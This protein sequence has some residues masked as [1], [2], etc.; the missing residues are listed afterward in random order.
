MAV[1]GGGVSGPV[2]SRVSGDEATVVV[3]P[4]Q[5]PTAG[6]P[7]SSGS[8]GR[9]R[10]VVALVVLLAAAGA[11]AYL[12][13]RGD[14]PARQAGP[15]DVAPSAADDAAAAR[16]DGRVGSGA[17]AVPVSSDADG[18]FTVTVFGTD[19]VLPGPPRGVR[20]ALA[21]G[22]VP[23]W[24]YDFEAAR[25]VAGSQPAPP[26]D[27]S[28]RQAV[29]DYE[30]AWVSPGTASADVEAIEDAI[31][32]TAAASGAHVGVVC[33]GGPS[34]EQTLACAHKIAQ[35]G[36]DAVILSD[37]PAATAAMEV[38]DEAGLPVVTFDVWHP[39]AVLVGDSSYE[40]GAVAG[41]HAGRHALD[42]WGCAGVHV[43][44]GNVMNVAGRDNLDLA[45]T[46]FA[47]G[48]RAVCGADVAVS[49]I[50]TTSDIAQ[51]TADWLTANPEVEH[52]VATSVT[53][54]LTV[55]MSR[56]IEQAGRSGIAAA[57]TTSSVGAARLAEGTTAET[58]YL[59]SAANLPEIHGTTAVA[60]L[61]D[62]LE[63]RPVPQE[64]HLDHTW[65]THNNADHPT[66]AQDPPNQTPNTPTDPTPPPTSTFTAITAGWLYS[67]AL[68]TDGAV[69]C[70]GYNGYSQADPPA[71]AF[72]AVTA[73]SDHSCGLRADNTVTCW[74]SN[75]GG[76]ADAPA[77]A[78]TAVSAGW[79]HSCGLRTD[80][81]VTCWGDNDDGRAD[82]PAG[83]FTAVSAGWW[84]S[85][86]L[87]TDNTIVCW[88]TNLHGEADAPAGA[89]TAVSAGGAYSCG[90]GADNTIVCW[91]GNL[92]GEADAPAGAFTAVSA[93]GSHSCG[94]RAD[95]TVMCW[96]DNESGQV[97][98]PAGAFT[99]VSAGSDHSCGVRADG[100]V[101]CWGGNEFGQVDA[102]TGAFTA[103]SAGEFHP[104]GIVRQWHCRLLEQQ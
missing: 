42:A 68:R 95:G 41:V 73:S 48:V 80:G 29:A 54:D 57:P 37:V 6:T 43:L 93:G 90:L 83:T 33:D 30:I 79:G 59:G 32:D 87:R 53:N 28:T 51:P 2:W 13:L 71:G 8:P 56:V 45:L 86:G 39:N 15:A 12:V 38:L 66:K 44:L 64:I 70:W 5:P 60:A 16:G 36:A 27:P 50:E 58:R 55:D 65:I 85:C 96:G 99:A 49:R 74:G 88:G 4:Q 46:G 47:D 34:T 103:D 25:F 26:F 9:W 104:C 69:V 62:I 92:H 24:T 18:V 77:G 10:G 89:F 3:P 94:V 23:S 21:A 102:P 82:A 19:Y 11:V 101:M 75:L 40:S 81:T 63:A 61:I 78:F 84:H 52:V 67:C 100:T 98:A 7:G 72:T 22:E 31:R 35:S 20:G 91:G 1:E 17:G 97:D 76:R 14:S